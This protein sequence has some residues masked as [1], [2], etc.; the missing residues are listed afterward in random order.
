MQECGL[1]RGK[2]SMEI[3]ELCPGKMHRHIDWLGMQRWLGHC[4]IKKPVD[5]TMPSFQFPRSGL[6]MLPGTCCTRVRF[7]NVPCCCHQKPSW[8]LWTFIPQF[9]WLGYSSIPTEGAYPLVN[10]RGKWKD[11]MP[12]KRIVLKHLDN[13]W[14]LEFA[15]PCFPLVI[16][17]S[18]NIA[19]YSYGSSA[20][21][22]H[23]GVTD[24]VLGLR[25]AGVT[26]PEVAV[27]AVAANIQHDP[28]AWV[29]KHDEQ[30]I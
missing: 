24:Q 22:P 17:Y 6:E 25:L 16:E 10:Q 5:K 15:H 9:Q 23:H 26:A 29:A 13:P 14:H 21:L 30:C 7:S 3:P 19:W 8:L 1:S 11:P 12:N 4:N 20:V 18:L 2:L 27:H 28:S